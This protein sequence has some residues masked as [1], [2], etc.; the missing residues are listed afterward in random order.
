M[1]E[2]APPP[3]GSVAVHPARRSRDHPIEVQTR[4]ELVEI[5]FRQLQVGAWIT[6]GGLIPLL[7]LVW[8]ESPPG[9]MVA[10]LAGMS[11]PIAATFWLGHRYRTASPPPPGERGWALAL[12]AL[13]TLTALGWGLTTWVFPTLSLSGAHRA[14][15][16]LLL[17]G[18][19]IASMRV[20]LPMRKGSITFVVA[21]ML[22]VA[23]HQA[24]GG[25]SSEPLLAGFVLLFVGL[26][27]W[28]NLRQH[29]SLS[30]AIAARFERESIAAELRDARERA[31]QANK[32]KD[33]FIANVS[34]ELR[35]P[36]NGVIG[37][38][39]IVRDTNLDAAQRSYLQTAADSAEALL[40]LVN[41]M[42]DF[43]KIETNRLELQYAPFSPGAAIRT[44]C[45]QYEARALEKGLQFRLSLGD[46]VPPSV[47]GDAA[48]L[49]QIIANLVSNAVKFTSRGSVNVRLE[50]PASTPA[51]ATLHVVVEDTG[52]GMDAATVSRLFRPFTQADASLSRRY[53][54]TG[55]GLAISQRLAQAMGG[56]LL[57]ESSP[58]VGT[59]FR[60]EV[61]CALPETTANVAGA[62]N[63]SPHLRGRVLVVEDDA[64]NRQVIE[65]FL[66]KFHLSPR[67]VNDGEAAIVAASAES[68]DLILM[69]CQ[70]PGIDGLEATRQ[71][72]RKLG[73]QPLKIVAVT[74]N[75]NPLMCEACL[76]AGMND[77][78]S[79]PVR[80]EQL[81]EVLQRYLPAS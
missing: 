31:E 34:H 7:V 66:Q 49:R 37:M 29:Q 50:C 38:L 59:T 30:E 73:T 51:R 11:V 40:G 58:G 77:F 10:W 64:V 20:L 5:A 75:A 71:I 48:R 68:F 54:G 24:L 67:L 2:S 76:A 78:L 53:G 43:A 16:L 70:L 57:V 62:A 23:L 55:L 74:A 26:A 45:E 27:L 52:I 46:T 41:D 21:M 6:L 80:F 81:A 1:S 35:T 56:K 4:I 3:S 9:P 69:D 12:V 28:T 22:P 42:L 47:L 17:A 65:L 14:A 19:T 32:A 8:K 63:G 13:S 39:R 15:H 33:E 44:V 72:R 25:A 79:K 18:L 36:M 60:L 61:T